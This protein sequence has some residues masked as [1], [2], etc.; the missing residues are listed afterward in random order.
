MDYRVKP[1]ND[2][3]RGL[4]PAKLE[5]MECARYYLLTTLTEFLI[6]ALFSI[7]ILELNIFL[8][9]KY[10]YLIIRSLFH[11]RRLQFIAQIIIAFHR[12]PDV[13]T[14]NPCP[15]PILG[16]FFPEHIQCLAGKTFFK[17]TST[18]LGQR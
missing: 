3:E 10:C 16:L 13:I 14:G 12:N 6:L 1:D 15:I 9:L 7:S 17:F 2:K 8:D 18:F 5:S 11:F 4:I